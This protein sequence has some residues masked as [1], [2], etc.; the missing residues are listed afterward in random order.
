[1]VVEN[2]RTTTPGRHPTDARPSP[3]LLLAEIG[4]RVVICRAA[5]SVKTEKKIA[6]HDSPSVAA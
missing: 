4:E 5:E 2:A 1:L 6:R 3:H